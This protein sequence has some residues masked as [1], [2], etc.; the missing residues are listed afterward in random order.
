ML[1]CLAGVFALFVVLIAMVAV[2]FHGAGADVPL[3][4]AAGS[5]L[6]L[7]VGGDPSDYPA[8]EFTF[9][10]PSGTSQT[11]ILSQLEAATADER[12]DRVL[13]RLSPFQAGYARAEELRAAIHRFRDTGRPVIAWTS[14]MNP[15]TYAVAVACDSIVML[16]DGPFIFEGFRSTRSFYR[17]TLDKIGVTMDMDRIESYKSAAEIYLRHDM[18]PAAREMSARLLN[19]QVTALRAALLEERGITAARFD[20]L[21]ARPVLLSDDALREGLIDGVAHYE[22]LLAGYAGR[23]FER[24]RLVNASDYVEVDRDALGLKGHRTI[25]VIHGEGFI[26]S[27]RSAPGPFEGGTIGSESMIKELRRAESNDDVA[28]IVL[29]L[30]TGGGETWASDAIG[31][32]VERVSAVKPIVISMADAC[33][34]GGYSIAYRASSIVALPGTLTG[35]IGS[36]TGKANISGLYEKLGVTHD[37]VEIGEHNGITSVLE[38]WTPEERAM[39][40]DRHWASYNRWITDIADHRGLAVAE[41]DSMARGRVWTGREA[42]PRK[43]VDRLGGLHEA[44]LEARSKAGIDSSETV[45]V[46]HFPRPRRPFEMLL[47]GEFDDFVTAAVTR[48]L[49]EMARSAERMAEM[50][51]LS[52]MEV[53]VP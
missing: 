53:A 41:L 30:D 31:H 7:P 37:G 48:A 1:G 46:E 27:G 15:K 35:S 16:P 5:T 25:A 22:D 36:F 14:F 11:E 18:S 47:E 9:R 40:K 33:A 32:E 13:L 24:H 44:I 39:I 43:L 4:I 21:L 3:R 34:S 28:A 23:D 52:V 2:L 12:I 45:S 42:L 6:V 38:S 50:K 26:A 8:S 49:G 51:S 17:G 29:R 20:S 19:E 10:G